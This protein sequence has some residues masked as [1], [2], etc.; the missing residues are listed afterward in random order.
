MTDDPDGGE[1]QTDTDSDTAAGFVPL[2]EKASRAITTTTD[3]RLLFNEPITLTPRGGGDTAGD[4]IRDPQ[5]EKPSYYTK[6]VTHIRSRIKQLPDDLAAMDQHEGRQGLTL[7]DE[8]RVT[9]FDETDLGDLIGDGLA[10]SLAADP[11]EFPGPYESPEDFVDRTPVAE[12]SQE[13]KNSGG[14][15]DAYLDE[16]EAAE[17]SLDRYDAPRV[18][19]IE[20]V[21]ERRQLDRILGN[22]D[23]DLAT[24]VQAALIA[25]RERGEASDELIEV[26]ADG[27]KELPEDDRAEIL[28]QLV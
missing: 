19:I 28:N 5:Q 12:I 24:F 25:A 7:G 13:I 18:G 9:V 22:T 14:T 2:P 4:E 8:L 17:R 3:R 27:I 23:R 6:N 11:D 15:Y 10:A 20:A 21:D 26:L 16:I 1:T